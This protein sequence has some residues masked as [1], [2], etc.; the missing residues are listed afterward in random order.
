MYLRMINKKA[1][2]EESKKTRIPELSSDIITNCLRTTEETLSLWHIDDIHKIDD[3]IIA[4]ASNRDLIQK[5]DYLIIPD[6]Y[7]EKYDLHLKE[8]DGKSPYEDFNKEH[9]DIINVDYEKLGIVSEMIL[10]I[11]NNTSSTIKRVYEDEVLAKLT[12]ALK[13]GKITQTK[14]KKSLLEAIA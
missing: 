13:D 5:L 9:R 2:W 3:A 4:L 8:N 12:E 7:I 6:E 1:K 10:D 14:L 11:M